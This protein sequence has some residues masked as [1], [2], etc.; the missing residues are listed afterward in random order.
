MRP[1]PGGG[2]GNGLRGRTIKNDARMSLYDREIIA[3]PVTFA[4]APFAMR[5]LTATSVATSFPSH[6]VPPT[7]FT[8]DCASKTAPETDASAGAASRAD[9]ETLRVAEFPIMAVA[10]MSPAVP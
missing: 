1:V 8:P 6:A 9:A 2:P 3:E 7:S 5:A 4:V 10:G